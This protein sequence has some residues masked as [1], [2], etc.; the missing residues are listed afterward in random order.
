MGEM[1]GKESKGVSIQAMTGPG[2]VRVVKFCTTVNLL[3]ILPPVP[4]SIGR[5]GREKRV[6]VG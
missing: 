4:T 5:P 6:D 1:I 2:A 3:F